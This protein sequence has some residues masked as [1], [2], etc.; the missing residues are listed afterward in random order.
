[1]TTATK[2]VLLSL[3]LTGIVLIFV[4]TVLKHTRVT[5]DVDCYETPSDV[6]VRASTQPVHAY[7]G[8]YVCGIYD[9]SALPSV[10]RCYELNKGCSK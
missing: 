4:F 8:L 2:E 7:G 3:S 5:K 10:I 9:R 6:D 1:M